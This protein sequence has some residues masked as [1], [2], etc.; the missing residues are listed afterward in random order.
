MGLT[1]DELKAQN[2]KKAEDAAAA[3]AAAQDILNDEEDDATQD[4][5]ILEDDKDVDDEFK[6]DESDDKD[7]ADE[8]DDVESLLSSISEDDDEKSVPVSS[9]IQM[10]QKLKGRIREGHKTIEDLQAENAALLEAA[11]QAGVQLPPRPK[12]EDF[13]LDDEAYEIAVEGWRDTVAEAK[14]YAR[15]QFEAQQKARAIEEERKAL[16]LTE[17]YN[18]AE[19][20]TER[21]KGEI[22]SDS[23]VAA[24]TVVRTALSEGAPEGAGDFVTD[25]L[26]EV[27]GTGSELVMY[28][29]GKKPAQLA[30][31]RQL[32]TEDPSGLSAAAFV[33]AQKTKL[34]TTKRSRSTAPPPADDAKGDASVNQAEA[35]LRR[36]YNKLRKSGQSQDAYNVK[37][38]AR[39]LGYSV[40]EW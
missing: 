18:R 1:L 26:I 39:G 27:L 17:H 36:K 38:E 16:A 13:P 23:Y 4:A 29:L 25:K 14:A 2:A 5:D 32:L 33:G 22:S 7:D 9:H 35:T 40:D 34:L 21:S 6:E 28:Y 10:R 11:A 12:K 37:K 20:L 19:K 3:D 8:N 31:L 24:E 15:R 30:K